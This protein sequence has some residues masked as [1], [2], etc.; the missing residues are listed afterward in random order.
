[1]EKLGFNSAIKSS[2]R[3]LAF[4]FFFFQLEAAPVLLRF[5]EIMQSASL[6]RAAPAERL[7]I[8]IFFKLTDPLA[9]FVAAL[10]LH[11][12][13]PKW[14]LPGWIIARLFPA[15]LAEG[16]KRPRPSRGKCVFRVRN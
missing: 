14:C 13:A 2:A 12:R 6:K 9:R 11:E 15:T 1:M 7:E 8:L 5:L 10:R 4:S 3:T 16:R